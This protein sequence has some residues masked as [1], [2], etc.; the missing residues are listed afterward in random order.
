MAVAI[1]TTP[2]MLDILGL[3]AE[4]AADEY[5]VP[6]AAELVFML[7]LAIGFAM[8]RRDRLGLT[9]KVSKKSAKVDD[10]RSGG[11]SALL[12]R[13][14][15]EC[16]TTSAQLDEAL[17]KMQQ[18]VDAGCHIPAQA[19]TDLCRAVCG[20]NGESLVPELVQRL[21]MPLNVDAC[22][23]LLEDCLKRS[24]LTSAGIVDEAARQQRLTLNVSGFDSLLKIY[25]DAGDV[26]ALDRFEAMQEADLRMS[27][28]LCVGIVA[29]CAASKFRRLAEAVADFG[30]GR[31]MMSL[32]M[33]SALMKVYAYEGSYQKACSL[34]DELRER[35]L[36]ADGVM[37]G[38]LLKFAMEAGRTDLIVHLAERTAPDTHESLML[39]KCCTQTKDIEKAFKI[40]NQMKEAG[41]LVDVRPYNMVLDVCAST[42]QVERARKFVQAMPVGLADEITYNV[43]MKCYT[44]KGDRAGAE[45]VLKEMQRAGCKPSSTTYNCLTNMAATAGDAAAAWNIVTQMEAAGVTPD[46]YT[47][48]IMMKAVSRS[49]DSALNLNRALSLLERTGLDICGDDVLFV[50][51]LE[52]CIK[53]RKLELIERI[54]QQFEDS[55]KLQRAS[56]QTHA[57]VIKGYGLIRRVDKCRE[58]FSNLVD[59]R[60]AVPSI[61]VVGCMLDALVCNGCVTEAVKLQRRL[62][63]GGMQ[64]NEVMYST[65]MKGLMVESD[66]DTALLLLD[67]MKADGL[68]PPVSIYNC[69]MD[70]Q[71]RLGNAP[72]AAALL[73]KMEAAGCGTDDTTRLMLIRSAT[74][75]GD[76]DKAVE[77]FFALSTSR[78]TSSHTSAYNTLV[79]G[80]V[81][82]NRLDLSAR[83]VS[84]MDKAGVR[85]SCF[86]LGAQI[87]HFGRSRCIWKAC[88]AVE[89][90]PRK[91][92]VFPNA[93]TKA[94]LVRGCIM[95]NDVKTASEILRDILKTERTL[96]GKTYR[97]LT[98]SCVQAGLLD[99][100]V[101]L[102]E[103]AFA[104]GSGALAPLA[105]ECF[106][107]DVL[108]T[109]FQALLRRGLKDKVARPLYE[110]LRGARSYRFNLNSR[111]TDKVLS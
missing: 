110:R 30:R 55:S 8:F 90:W 83:L 5:S 91:Y 36:E 48:A 11:G 6:F 33:Y 19:V 87:K 101:M 23:V 14:Q 59:R 73:Q 18:S 104:V 28:G 98:S 26:R 17:R 99:E 7:F 106:G 39:I 77:T 41:Q 89:T 68:R 85:P 51:V 25:A 82:A 43:L 81:Q 60:G 62:R 54:L 102:V 88:E 61:I 111:L 97:S 42:G 79:S 10:S 24:D 71:N 96:D 57:V 47:I 9:K 20:S 64:T 53:Q 1:E 92:R 78:G 74:A 16:I 70:A 32:N 4:A 109:V 27:E 3:N 29:R 67:E 103:N 108:E 58:A 84:D 50:T 94:C 105:E 100:A 37:R 93:G 56:M 15:R 72:K 86:T 22:A 69:V 40:F 45:S 12:S 63:S 65:L 49:A 66:L 38:C 34:Y 35:N 2:T 21:V 44:G 46:R 13:W 75:H 95:S 80:C 31:G 107:N 52:T 76:Y